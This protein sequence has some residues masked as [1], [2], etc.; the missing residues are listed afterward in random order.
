MSPD[1]ITA[2][3]PRVVSALDELRRLIAA[4]YP[5]ARFTVFEGEDPEG[6][7]L[8]ATVDIEDSSD[9]LAPVLDKLYEL[10][11]E[12]KLPIYVVT[13]QPEE[14]VAAQLAHRVDEPRPR[15]SQLGL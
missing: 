3:D 15:F 4:Q 7:Y 10:E 2:T 13:S 1:H 14:R 9:A 8:R 6:V 5:D 11:V 12:R